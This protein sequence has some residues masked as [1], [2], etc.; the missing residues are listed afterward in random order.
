[1]N[2]GALPMS[3]GLTRLQVQFLAEPGKVEELLARKRTH[4]VA[5]KRLLFV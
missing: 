5:Q 4:G 1:M 3:H 2:A